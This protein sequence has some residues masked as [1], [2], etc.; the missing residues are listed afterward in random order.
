MGM[1]YSANFAETVEQDFVKQTCPKEFEN[2]MDALDKDEN[3]TLEEFAKNVSFDENDNKSD[4]FK[5]YEKLTESFKAKTGLNLYL[6]F[7]D[8]EN[9]GDRYDDLSGT[10]WYLDFDE[11]YKL[12]VAAHKIAGKISRRYFV[13]LG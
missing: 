2:F 8:Q 13:T 7:H 1:G 11:V 6:G 5:S 3:I 9:D 10:F 4:V 12:S